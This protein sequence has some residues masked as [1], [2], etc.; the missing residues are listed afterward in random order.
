MKNAKILLADKKI[1]ALVNNKLQIDQNAL[2]LID[3][4]A[5]IDQNILKL[6]N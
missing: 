3:V 4:K 6:T 2:G 5:L 1:S